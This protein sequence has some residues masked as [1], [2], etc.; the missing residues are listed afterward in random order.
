MLKK[1][2]N[3]MLWFNMFLTSFIVLSAF[4]FIYIIN[5]RQIES[6]IQNLILQDS[7]MFATVPL[8][9]EELRKAVENP[10][11]P[12]LILTI[13]S[14][15]EFRE[16]GEISEGTSDSKKI[17][18]DSID[19]GEDLYKMIE[20]ADRTLGEVQKDNRFWRYVAHL[21]EIPNSYNEE[22]YLEIDDWEPYYQ[23]VFFDVTDYKKSL[24]N[25]KSTL[26][27]IGFFSLTS[28][29]I[30]S[31]HVAKRSIKPVES[32]WK[33]QQEFI[34]N[35]S[36]ELKTPLSII[37][38]NNEVLLN[39]LE[40]TVDSQLKWLNNIHYGTERMGELVN[41]LLILTKFENSEYELN[42]QE[43]NASQIIKSVYQSFEAIAID[44]G[45]MYQGKIEKGI[46]LEINEQALKQLTMILIDNALK[47]T[48][49][50]SSV[51]IELLDRHNKVSLCVSNSGN[52]IEEDKI[53]LLFDRFY[54]LDNSRCTQDGGFGLGLAIVKA[55]TDQIKAEVNINVTS[56]G[57]NKFEISFKK[58]HTDENKK[59]RNFS[60]FWS[61]W[62]VDSGK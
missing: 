10:Q 15:S 8:T 60:G 52:P 41:S 33:K 44:K 17:D 26:I 18:V 43:L 45:I 29:Y 56:D 25:L 19:T 34:S 48:P 36:H 3:Q 6:E 58:K 59:L 57:T 61:L 24:Q 50:S 49:R 9:D 28:I 5:A 1:L 40:N 16:L 27:Y 30:V 14:T 13:N 21:I 32:A 55:L 35:A 2:R 12:I 54:R 42:K 23:I 37:K 22:K 4:M 46:Y 53:P 20:N 11:Y 51:S 62:D 7:N 38:I 39:N 31:F 47:Y